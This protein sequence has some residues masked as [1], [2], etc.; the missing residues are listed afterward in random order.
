MMEHHR[1]GMNSYTAVGL[2]QVCAE[3]ALLYQ[4]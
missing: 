2:L 4:E 3:L 1:F